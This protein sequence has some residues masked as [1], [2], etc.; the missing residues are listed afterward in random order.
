MKDGRFINVASQGGRLV[1]ERKMVSD[2]YVFDLETFAWEKL[3]PSPEDE[4][5]GPRYFH[6]ADTCNV[7]FADF[8]ICKMVSDMYVFDLETFAWEKL[9]PSPEDEVPGPRY[10]HSADTCNVSFADF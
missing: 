2:M 9:L 7:S 6:S 3:L 1:T 10:F 5:P 8:Q 4:V